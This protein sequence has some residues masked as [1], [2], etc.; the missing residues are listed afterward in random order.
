MVCKRF[1]NRKEKSLN[2]KFY[3]YSLEKLPA[4]QIMLLLLRIFQ[5]HKKQFCFAD[6]FHNVLKVMETFL[7]CN[8]TFLIEKTILVFF[9]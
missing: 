3:E 9:T 6:L 2:F 4:V 1:E 7:G 8:F 5:T